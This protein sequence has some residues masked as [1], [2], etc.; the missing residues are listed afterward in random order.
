MKTKFVSNRRMNSLFEAP[1]GSRASI[2]F[3]NYLQGVREIVEFRVIAH[4]S[5]YNVVLQNICHQVIF[6]AEIV[7]KDKILI[8]NAF[9][10]EAF[11]DTKIPD[12]ELFRI[13]EVLWIES[14]SENESQFEYALTDDEL[15]DDEIAKCV[16]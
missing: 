15:T 7:C 1:I 14:N 5:E 4:T 11:Q 12:E 2:N 9:N 10:L 6:Q 13:G 16:L 3:H 8:L